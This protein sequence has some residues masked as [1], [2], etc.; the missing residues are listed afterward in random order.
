[1]KRQ[2]TMLASTGLPPEGP[3]GWW[4]SEKFDGEQAIWD[5]GITRGMAC[6]DVPFA[7]TEKHSRYKVKPRATGL[8]S[9]YA[10]PIQA[11]D[12]WLDALPAMP[13]V[14]EIWAGFGG[15]QRV[16][17]ARKLVPV[18][19]E[20]SGI[21]YQVFDS[22]HVGIWLA[23]GEIDIPNMKLVIPPG[24]EAWFRDRGCVDFGSRLMLMQTYDLLRRSL[25]ENEVVRLVAQ[26][27]LESQSHL[28]ELYSSVL[29]NGGEGGILRDPF[30]FWVPGRSKKCFKQKPFLDAEGT[31]V[32]W[33]AGQGKYLGMMGALILVWGEKVFKISGFTD[34]ERR[35]DDSY[36]AE[37]YPGEEF[38][39]GTPVFPKG[40]SVTFKYREL[41]DDGFP[42]EA[43]YWRKRS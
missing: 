31:V 8:W 9:R 7:Y 30:S 41:T 5:G 3:Q 10:Q 14:G 40:S 12:W 32:G 33:Q 35:V 2:F 29:A 6:E 23:A 37:Q 38:L 18:D 21:T 17:S 16:T 26:T 27:P 36:T 19:E 42:K 39:T 1:M 25:T 24:M 34:A 4:F 22:P 13:V 43:R 28:E 20:W 15:Y 11:P